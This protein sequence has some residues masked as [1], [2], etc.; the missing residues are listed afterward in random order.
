M[1]DIV[2]QIGLKNNCTFCGVFRRQALDRGA[3]QLNCDSIVTGH[4]ADDLAET[5]LM[6]VLR[7]DIARLKR[8]VYIVT[9]N[10]KDNQLN[11]DNNIQ[12]NEFKNK[13]NQVNELNNSVQLEECC[14]GEL[15]K[16]TEE[17]NQC[18]EQNNNCCNDNQSCFN[19]L[20]FKS[21]I[22][23]IPRSKPFKYTYEKGMH[24]KYFYFLNR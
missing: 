6:N 23:L 18:C 21:P 15:I 19:R 8:S 11:D 7:G 14:N 24:L 17:G 1:D 3:M 13:D 5:I 22:G 12:K 2:K 16:N 20:I 10:K 9:E 4:N